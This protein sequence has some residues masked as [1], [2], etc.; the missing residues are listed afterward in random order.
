M[1]KLK[2]P[3]PLP[4]T[5]RA[6]NDRSVTL[7]FDPAV[8][9]MKNRLTNS[10][11][12]H[13]ALPSQEEASELPAAFDLQPLTRRRVSIKIAS[14]KAATFQFSPEDEVALGDDNG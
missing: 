12:Q 14:V 3:P 6:G 9:R 5:R 13:E 7:A 8:V 10:V 1:G 11:V 2:E 4:R